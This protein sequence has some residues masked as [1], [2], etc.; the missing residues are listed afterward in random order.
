MEKEHIFF[1]ESFYSDSTIDHQAS[2]Q[3]TLIMLSGD[4]CASV[5]SKDNV[6]PAIVQTPG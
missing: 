1:S 3:N 2:K 6:F 4:R 5:K